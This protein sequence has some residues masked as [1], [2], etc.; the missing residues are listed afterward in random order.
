TEEEKACVNQILHDAES[1]FAN[2]DAEIVRPEAAFSALMHKRKCLQDYVAQH[3]SLLAPVRR[4]PPEVLSL[5][6]LTH[7]RQESSKN[8]LVFGKP[9]GPG[10]RLT[11]IVLSQVS[12]GWRRLALESPRLW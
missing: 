2:Y 8:T 5:I 1:D 11:S 10:N 4:L 9:K 7:C 6:F 12:I 3:R